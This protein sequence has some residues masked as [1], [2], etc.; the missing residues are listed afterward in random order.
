MFYVALRDLQPGE[1]LICSYDERFRKLHYDNEQ[2][3]MLHKACQVQTLK[4]APP[5][6]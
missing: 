5:P 3:S 4:E 6:P 1:E 2:V